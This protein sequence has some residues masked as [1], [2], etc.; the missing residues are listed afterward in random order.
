MGFALEVVRCNG[1]ALQHLPE[2]H[3]SD[4]GIVM[5]AVQQYGP[6]LG[7]ASRALCNDRAIVLSAVRNRQL[8]SFLP[9]WARAR[10][11]LAYA[12]E[13]LREDRALVLE[14]VQA[15]GHALQHAARHLQCDRQIAIAAARS[16]PGSLQWA[17]PACR[18]DRQVLFYSAAR[19]QLLKHTRPCFPA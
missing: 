17:T 8:G 1:A 15:D 6:A 10:S 9:Y 3:R 13:D 11:A 16:A 7:S 2:Q 14:A 4:H 5:K 19:R 18:H 12:S